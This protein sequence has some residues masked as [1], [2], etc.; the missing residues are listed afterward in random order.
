MW[1]VLVTR[2]V[3]YATHL[4]NVMNKRLVMTT[5]ELIL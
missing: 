5:D 4:V 1:P 3:T 2:L